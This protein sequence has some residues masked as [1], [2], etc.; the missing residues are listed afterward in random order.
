MSI[1]VGKARSMTRGNIFKNI[2]LA[3]DPNINEEVKEE[4]KVKKV[5]MAQENDIIQLTPEEMKVE[6][7]MQNEHMDEYNRQL[8]EKKL[9]KLL[10]M[11]DMVQRYNIQLERKIKKFLTGELEEQHF[12]LLD[13]YQAFS[14]DVEKFLKALCSNKN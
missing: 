12:Q 6:E 8:E 7:Q 1:Q 11:L 9:D 5:R 13:Q 4:K 3:N 14:E 2:T 10:T